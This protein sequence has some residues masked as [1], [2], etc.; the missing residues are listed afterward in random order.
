MYA[1]VIIAFWFIAYSVW[2]NAIH[3]WCLLNICRKASKQASKRKTRR[4]KEGRRK[5]SCSSKS[6]HYLRAPRTNLVGCLQRGCLEE[7]RK[8]GLWGMVQN[9]LP[10]KRTTVQFKFSKGDQWNPELGTFRINM[11]QGI[12][13]DMHPLPPL[14]SLI[15][16][17]SSRLLRFIPFNFCLQSS[18]S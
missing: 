8:T 18:G 9:S 12:Q 11:I 15:L 1:I 3:D 5:M 16:P 10:S 14:S 6:F 4:K 2:S 17:S 13:Q 7:V